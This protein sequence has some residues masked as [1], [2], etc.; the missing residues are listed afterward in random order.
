MKA[1]IL[2]IDRSPDAII[3]QL[4]T[5][6]ANEDQQSRFGSL[7]ADRP[8]AELASEQIP[9]SPTFTCG[10]TINQEVWA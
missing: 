4:M 2:R 8:A 3:C 9:S 6:F 10:P 1:L 5:L 7:Q